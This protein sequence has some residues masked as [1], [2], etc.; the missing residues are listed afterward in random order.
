VVDDGFYFN[1]FNMLVFVYV[2]LLDKFKIVFF[3]FYATSRC[4]QKS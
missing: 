4:N 2:G 1:N 3:L